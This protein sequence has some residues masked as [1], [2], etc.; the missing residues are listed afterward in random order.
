M[1]IK[2]CRQKWKGTMT[3]RERFN[4][5]MHYKPVDRCF[6]MEFGYWLENFK[7]WPLFVENN[8]TNNTEAD[9]FFN[10]DE[11]KVIGGNVW[12]APLFPQSVV[13]END[14]SKIIMNGDGLLAEIPKDGHDTIPH[15]MKASVVTP[16]DWK[17]C[18]AERMRRDDPARKVDFKA[19]KT[20]H[21][22]TRN[23]PLGVSC[24]SMIGKIRDMLTFEGLAYAVYD[25][26]DMV[27]DMVETCCTL[28]EDFLDQVLAHIDFDFAS[29]WEDICFKNG[30]I[31]SVDFFKNVV[32]PRY[33]RI[34]RKLKAAGIDI[35]YM[36]CDGDVRPILPY[37]MEGGINCLFPF[38]VNGCAHPAVL[39]KEYDKDLR[40]M[41]GVDKL[42]L[43][44]G[45]KAIQAYLKT[46]IPLVERGGYIPFCD[47]RCPPNVKPEDY[48]YYLDL[49]EQM[50]GLAAYRA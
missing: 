48:L 25:Y 47:H 41:G 29:G 34:H 43:G 24:G 3:D 9:I 10:F 21:P 40:I 2:P 23:Y 16:D 33:K 39:L 37:F 22:L 17:R 49:K 30:P 4:N 5:Q 26:P 45:P 38:E 42:E 44:K 18:K 19:L 6:N 50:F 8:V 12:L 28:V 32:T 36:D 1:T 14:T 35:W 27:E 20:A 13:S 15:F 11:F 7:L 31:V 46:L